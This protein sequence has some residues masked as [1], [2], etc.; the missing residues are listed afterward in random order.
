[1][2]TSSGRSPRRP[3]PPLDQDGLERLA[4]HYV[5]RYATT[6][7]RVR[8][9]LNR[10]LRE[11]GWSGETAPAV[12]RV[13]ERIATLGYVDDAAFASA[14]AAA[15]QRRGYG[16]RRIAQALAVAGIGEDDR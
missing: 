9:Y 1:M 8:D 3:R 12:D 7:A 2:R 11:R 15:M 4:L 14:R 6:R 16:G 5:G 10:K 13:V